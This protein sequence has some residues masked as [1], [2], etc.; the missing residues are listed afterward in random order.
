MKTNRAEIHRVFWFWI[1]CEIL[2][3]PK[4]TFINIKP[5]IKN[6]DWWRWK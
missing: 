1:L 6:G 5:S 3:M 2:D 4:D